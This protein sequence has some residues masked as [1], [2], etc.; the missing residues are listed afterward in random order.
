VKGKT[1]LE[2]SFI[3]KKEKSLQKTANKR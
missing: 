2:A 3:S 1:S